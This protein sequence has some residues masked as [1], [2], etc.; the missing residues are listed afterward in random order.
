[1]VVQ[2]I[3]SPSDKK[4]KKYMA[5]IDG[6]KSIHFGQAGASD[7]TLHKNEDR[8]NRYILRHQKN[9]DWNDYNTAGFYSKH[10][11]WNKPTIIESIRDT[12]NKFK[13]INIKFK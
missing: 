6:K 13:N 4:D 1:M 2:I 12:N 11:L 7:M 9:E 5:R 8:K 10:I 3:I